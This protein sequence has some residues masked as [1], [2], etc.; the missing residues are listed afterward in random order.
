MRGIRRVVD[1][2]PDRMIVG[3]VYLLDLH[4]VVR[5]LNSGDQLHP[6][7]NFVFLHL[8]WSAEAFRTSIDDVEALAAETLCVERQAADPRSTLS[9]FRGLTALR[10]RTPALQTGA[11]R[12]VEAGRASRH[13]RCR[14]RRRVETDLPD[15]VR[16]LMRLYPQ[17]RNRRPSVEYLPIPYDD[18]RPERREPSRRL[19]GP[20]SRR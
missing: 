5:Y 16:E 13:S 3:Q 9:L 4:R 6:A 18:R 7:H 1:E 10:R 20:R 12:C 8:P 2:Y 15:E 19:P 14:R 11:Q 17:P